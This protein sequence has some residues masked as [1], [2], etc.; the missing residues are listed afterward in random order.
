LGVF[1]A[2]LTLVNNQRHKSADT[3]RDT[4]SFFFHECARKLDR[5]V[6]ILASGEQGQSWMHGIKTTLSD[7]HFKEVARELRDVRL[8]WK[9][10]SHDAYREAF[11][12]RWADIE[13]ELVFELKSMSLQDYAQLSW[14]G[15]LPTIQDNTLSG[16][17]ELEGVMKTRHS[18]MGCRREP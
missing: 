13:H 8:L 12:L 9:N 16:S 5:V 17:S 1:V 11:Q 18:Q 3:N 6:D 2:W 15:E 4:S 7:A 10:I 14:G